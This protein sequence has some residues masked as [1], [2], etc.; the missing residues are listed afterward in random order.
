MDFNDRQYVAVVINFFWGHG[1]TT[2]KGVNEEAAL[3]AYEALEQAKVCSS[4]MNLVPRPTYAKSG[5]TYALKQLAMIG[6][7]IKQGDTAIYNSC[8]GV[9]GLRYKTR[10]MMALAGV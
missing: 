9:V 10:I 4:S 7:R 3:V 8:K 6:K 1:T 2:P 5:I